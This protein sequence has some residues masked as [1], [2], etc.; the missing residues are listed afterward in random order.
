M[1]LLLVAL[2]A[3]VL[4]GLYPLPVITTTADTIVTIFVSLLKLISLPIIFLAIVSTVTQLENHQEIKVLGGRVMK[5]T[6]LT[7]IIAASIALGLFLWINPVANAIEFIE[8]DP[9]FVSNTN[10]WDYLLSSVPSN[11]ITPFSEGNVIAILLL[12]LLMS[13]AILSLPVRQKTYL[14]ELFSNLFA[15]I[16]EIAKLVLKFIPIA[17]WAFITQFVVG[18]E[19]VAQLAA[20]G[21]YIAC[22]VLANVI[23]AVIVLPGLLKVKKLSPWKVFKAMAPALNVGFW[24]KSSAATLPVTLTCAKERLGISDKVAGFSLPLCTT[25]NM[26]ACAGFITITVLFVAMSNGMTFTAFELAAWVLVATLAAIGNAGV[27]MGCYFLSLALLTTMNVPLN[28]MF[29]IL[30]FFTLLDMLE[31]SIN[32]WSDACVTAVVDKEISELKA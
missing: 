32:I 19:S 8:V 30:P 16:L 24:S 12:A 5:Y 17:I 2:V 10:Y 14:N 13:F 15:A 11:M 23:Q 9:S 26:N 29:I 6:L 20:I 22:V 4:S 27:P 7:T 28:L 18:F 3:G 31:T 25:I 1:F 21:L